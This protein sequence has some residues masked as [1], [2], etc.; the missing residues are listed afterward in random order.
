ME[1]GPELRSGIA[2][3][4]LFGFALIAPVIS[5]ALIREPIFVTLAPIFVSHLF[6]LCATLI[7]NNQW[8]GPVITSFDTANDEV[9]L[10]IDDGPTAAHT[11]RMLDVLQR[12]DA[13]ATFFVIGANAEKHPHLVT[14][15]LTRGHAVANHTFTHPAWTFWCVGPKR[16]AREVAR[17]SETLRATAERPDRLFR[18]PAGMKSPFLHPVLAPR[19]MSVV[20]WTV[21]GLDTVSRDAARVA[22]RIDKRIRPGAIV[23]LHDGHQLARDP[24]FGVRCLELTLE[25]LAARGYRFVIPA[26]EQL[27][28]R[29]GGR[30]TADC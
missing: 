26:P 7:A 8:W 10:T 3:A 14:E 12:F 15:I 29:A 17:C 11:A 24:D 6:L 1:A 13:R 4:L 28:T 20:G 16:I 19:S 30:R 5:L 2:R 21:R 27:R 25:R 22:E 23:L 9:W 18:A